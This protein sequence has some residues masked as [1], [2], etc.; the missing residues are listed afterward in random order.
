MEQQ[1]LTKAEGLLVEHKQVQD[2]EP[3]WGCRPVA[4]LGPHP[5]VLMEPRPVVL[6]ELHGQQ[7]K[8]D[9]AEEEK[10][11]SCI[12][13]IQSAQTEHLFPVIS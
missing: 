11:Y 7:A 9:L 1:K 8:M 10:M 2:E 12:V 5:V 4:L 13:Q 6:M 3:L